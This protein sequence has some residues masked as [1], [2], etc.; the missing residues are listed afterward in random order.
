MTTIS[1]RS[2][3]AV[4]RIMSKVAEDILNRSSDLRHRTHGMRKKMR[5]MIKYEGVVNGPRW[6]PDNGTC[7]TSAGPVVEATCRPS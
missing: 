5:E 4:Q 6:R 7:T 1:P 2:T 3:I